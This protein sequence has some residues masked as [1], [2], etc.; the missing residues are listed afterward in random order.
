MQNIQEEHFSHSLVIGNIIK[1]PEQEKQYIPEFSS[2]VL[3]VGDT[4]KQPDQDKECK[5]GKDFT[6]KERLKVNMDKFKVNMER[7]KK[8]KS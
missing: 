5:W 1:Q 2:P 7:F 4:I 6:T 8:I 3:V